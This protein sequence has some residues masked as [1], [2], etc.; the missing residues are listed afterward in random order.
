[1]QVDHQVHVLLPCLNLGCHAI[2][3]LPCHLE[4]G[5]LG[6]AD[7]LGHLLNYRCWQCLVGIRVSKI[8]TISSVDPI[9]DQLLR[10]KNRIDQVLKEAIQTVVSTKDANGLAIGDDWCCDRDERAWKGL[11]EWVHCGVGLRVVLVLL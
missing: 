6:C 5:V 8:Q 2:V 4:Q 10:I 1:M 7:L 9:S 3:L 11:V